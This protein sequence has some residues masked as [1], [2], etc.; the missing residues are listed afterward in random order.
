[1]F[2]LFHLFK[3]PLGFSWFFTNWFEK[4]NEPKPPIMAGR[5]RTDRQTDKLTV[6]LFH[7]KHV[8]PNYFIQ[9]MAPKL[10]DSDP[11]LSWGGAQRSSFENNPIW[12]MMVLYN[13]SVLSI[14]RWT[15]HAPSFGDE[16]PLSNTGCPRSNL[17]E[18]IAWRRWKIMKVRPIMILLK[19]YV[20]C[21]RHPVVFASKS[22][23]STT[24]CCFSNAYH[25]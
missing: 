6:D 3:Y 9:K 2:D 24:S 5:R 18:T 17:A 21:L 1:M 7:K 11:L 12:S 22:T 14:H 16:W 23:C 10:S 8:F 4:V 13:S 15:V 19:K 20:F 25:F